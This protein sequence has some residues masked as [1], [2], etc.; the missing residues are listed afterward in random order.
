[1]AA[2]EVIVPAESD[3]VMELAG[4][5]IVVSTV[6][7]GLEGLRAEVWRAVLGKG[8]GSV[9]GGGVLDEVAASI[10]KVVVWVLS[11]EGG[12]DS[13]VSMDAVTGGVHGIGI[14]NGLRR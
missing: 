12:L 14:V 1:M 6:E 9:T 2:P 13:C 4:R 3:V 5:L 8:G 10:C 7:R 11:E